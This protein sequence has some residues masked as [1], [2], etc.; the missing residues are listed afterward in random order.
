V[1]ASPYVQQGNVKVGIDGVRRLFDFSS[2]SGLDAGALELE[3]ALNYKKFVR[4]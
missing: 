4:D 3:W 1:Q 2:L